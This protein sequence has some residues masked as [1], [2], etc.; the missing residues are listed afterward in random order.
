M[1]KIKNNLKIF[2]ICV[3]PAIGFKRGINSY[4][5]NFSEKKIHETEIINYLYLDK[6]IWGI[7]SALVYLNPI[8]C[9]RMGYKEMYRLE[10]NLRGLEDEKKTKY[11]N[12]VF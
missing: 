1:N 11:Y 9:F 7:G 2:F 3:W 8:L 5:Y 10:V 12:E 4:N 6:F